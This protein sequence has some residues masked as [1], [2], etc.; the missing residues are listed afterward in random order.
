MQVC[1]RIFSFKQLHL[2]A[3]RIEDFFLPST[4]CCCGIWNDIMLIPKQFTG[5]VEELLSVVSFTFEQRSLK[6]FLI[7]KKFSSK[8]MQS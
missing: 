3:T 1:E 5:F 7:R 8:Q 4:R 6:N 2:I